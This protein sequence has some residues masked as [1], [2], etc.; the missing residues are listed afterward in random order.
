VIAVAD[1]LHLPLPDKSIDLVFGSPPYMDARTYGIDSEETT[2]DAK[3][4]N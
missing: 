3:D 1:A 4:R 2:W